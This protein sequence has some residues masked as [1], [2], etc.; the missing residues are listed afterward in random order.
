V[1]LELYPTAREV[2]RRCAS[3]PGVPYVHTAGGMCF[4]CGMS[5]GGTLCGPAHVAEAREGMRREIGMYVRLAR[6]GNLNLAASWHQGGRHPAGVTMRALLSRAPDGMARQALI[7][8]R[9]VL[10]PVAIEQIEPP[11]LR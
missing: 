5:P 6:A 9:A 3:I 2:C 11:H 10:P 4:G 1:C 8:L 7:A